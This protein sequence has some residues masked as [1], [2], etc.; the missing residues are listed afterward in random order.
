[1]TE[2]NNRVAL[3]PAQA[4][5]YLGCSTATLWRWA[6]TLEHFPQPHRLPGQRVTVWF[7]DELEAWMVKQSD[8][9][10]RRNAPAAAVPLFH[11]EDLDAGRR[12]L[13]CAY[14]LDLSPF[15]IWPMSPGSDPGSTAHLFEHLLA[16]VE[17][18]RADAP[19]PNPA[20]LELTGYLRTLAHCDAV[21]NGRVPPEVRGPRGFENEGKYRRGIYVQKGGRGNGNA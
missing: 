16:R 9:A 15:E 20:D 19:E 12:A 4:A 6:K 7:Q 18:L 17:Q 21:L 5:T 13:W 10:W 3:R 2:K 8:M 14:L 11:P 1:M